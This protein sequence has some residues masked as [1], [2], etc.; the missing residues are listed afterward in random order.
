MQRSTSF[1][2]NQALYACVQLQYSERTL[3]QLL[4]QRTAQLLQPG[5]TEMNRVRGG[6]PRVLPA[7]DREGIAGMACGVVAQLNMTTFAEAAC[8]LAVLSGIGQQPST[9][10]PPTCVDC[11]C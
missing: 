10:T 11:G 3:L 7:R 4:L 8:A 9:H 1:A 6:R 5:A 2:V